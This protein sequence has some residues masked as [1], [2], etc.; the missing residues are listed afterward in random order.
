M[1]LPYCQK[2]HACYFIWAHSWTKHNTAVSL[3]ASV[4]ASFRDTIT[5]SPPWLNGTCAHLG[6]VVFKWGVV[7]VVLGVSSLAKP[8]YPSTTVTVI[9]PPRT[10]KTQGLRTDLFLINN[11]KSWVAATPLGLPPTSNFLPCSY[12]GPTAWAVLRRGSPRRGTSPHRKQSLRTAQFQFF[13]D[14][15]VSHTL[16]TVLTLSQSPPTQTSPGPTWPP[17]GGEKQSKAGTRCHAHT[18]NK[19]NKQGD[20][21]RPAPFNVACTHP[22]SWRMEHYYILYFKSPSYRCILYMYIL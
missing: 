1:Q 6:R 5:F 18:H 20:A 9:H 4:I 8:R 16:H 3:H 21:P 12:H 14:H 10:T 2:V 11:K 22:E 19:E 17:Q 15:P 13:T 7:M